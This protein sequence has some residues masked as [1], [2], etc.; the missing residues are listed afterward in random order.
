[1]LFNWAV[2]ADL[3]AQNPTNALRVID[4]RHQSELRLPYDT[5]E[6]KLFFE[7]APLFS[8]CKASHRR[9]IPGSKIIKDS[10]FWFPLFAL[11]SGARLGEIAAATVNDFKCDE[12]F[13]YLD[14]HAAKDNK[15]LKTQASDRR[16]PIHPELI[17]MGFLEYLEKQQKAGLT[18]VFEHNQGRPDIRDVRGWSQFWRNFQRDLGVTD[19]RKVF[20]SFRHNFKSACRDAEIEEEVHDAITGHRPYMAGRRYGWRISLKVLAGAMEKV[21]YPGLDLSH[22][23]VKLRNAN[24]G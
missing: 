17:K 8:G 4:R 23:H 9:R 7:R 16:V 22:L 1:M 14:I 13:H 18:Q 10:I 3:C 20:H 12:G 19:R 11:F 24:S 2:A 21:R 15:H 5:E 6:L